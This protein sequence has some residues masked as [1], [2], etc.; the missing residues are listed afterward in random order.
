[1]KLWHLCWQVHRLEDLSG[2]G[3]GLDKRD[4]GMRL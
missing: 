1:M 4:E 2:D 3:V